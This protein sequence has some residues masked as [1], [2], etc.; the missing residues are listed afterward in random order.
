MSE[1]LE[2]DAEIRPSLQGTALN[3]G[4]DLEFTDFRINMTRIDEMQEERYQ[5]SLKTGMPFVKHR[6]SPRIVL[7]AIDE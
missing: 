1:D 5:D 2:I 3:Y 7:E 6:M 4:N